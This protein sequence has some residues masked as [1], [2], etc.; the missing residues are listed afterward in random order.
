MKRGKDEKKVVLKNFGRIGEMKVKEKGERI[1]LK[2]K[3]RKKLDNIFKEFRWKIKKD[4]K[5]N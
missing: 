1:I 2:K 3:S 5:L 4:W